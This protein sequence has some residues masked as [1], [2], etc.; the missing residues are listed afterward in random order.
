MYDAYQALLFDMDGTLVDSGRLHELTW[1]ATLERYGIPVDVPLMRS[2]AGVPARET[3]QRL[4]R[5]FGCSVDASIDE[6]VAFKEA[7]VRE[8]AHRY[9][10][11]TALI[12][13]VQTHHGRKPMAV[14]TGASTAEAR[15]T[16]RQCGLD[17]FFDIVVGADQV[18]SP[19]PAPDTFLLCAQ[20]LAV[21]PERCVVFED[22]P[23]G[24]Q[25]ARCAGM[26]AVDVLQVHGIHNDYFL[27]PR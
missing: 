2:L 24:L 25:A 18:R 20:L 27:E 14:G 6:M 8:D 4:V 17:A 16:L 21:R 26:E 15:S 19:K 7:R 5:H 11:P 10:R 12:E 23:M 13:V 9:V 1:R 3:L 22:S